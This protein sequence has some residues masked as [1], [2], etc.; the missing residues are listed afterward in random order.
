[1][2]TYLLQKVYRELHPEKRQAEGKRRYEKIKEKLSEKHLCECGKLYTFGHKKR[3][4]KSQKHQNYLKQQS[5][6]NEEQ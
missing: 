5:E 6:V 4:E 1:M 2:I 3:H